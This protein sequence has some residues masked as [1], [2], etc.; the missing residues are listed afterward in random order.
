MTEIDLDKIH[1]R[2]ESYRDEIL[3]SLGNMIKIPAISPKS[4]GEGEEKKAEFILELIAN[5]GF[6]E[7][8]R[9]DVPDESA[10]KKIRPNIIAKVRGSKDPSEGTIWIVTHMDVVPEGE[11]ELWETPPYEPFVKDGKIFGRGVEDNGQGLISSLYAVKALK[12]EGVIPNRTIGIAL[13][14][15]EETGSQFGI[16]PLIEKGLF[17]ENDL[18]VV[19]DAGTSDGSMME[20][21]EKSI[22]WV[23]IKTIGK[24][25]H[26]SL[27]YKG[28]NA[29][30]A[31]MK[32]GVKLD[33]ELHKK[34]DKKDELFDPPESTFEPTKKESNV[35]N[36]NTIPGED[37][38]YFDCRVLPDYDPDEV[39]SMIKSIAKEIEEETRAKFQI[40]TPQYEPAAPP[41]SP[42]SPVVLELKEAIKKVYKIEPYAGGIGGGTCAALFRKAGY[43][44]VVWAKIDETAH[45]PN[46][47]AWIDNIV[48]DTKVYATLFC[49]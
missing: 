2:I 9:I 25:C 47:Y 23:K 24:Q 36:V 41:T 43:P 30:R 44:A 5:F 4:G 34:Y 8:D 1:Q 17:S 28:I 37:V 39:L 48:N 10:P 18:I 16:T 29:H 19:P 6:D 20:V 11:L 27:P 45:S 40:E 33:E 14:A 38:L 35:P 32:F 7:I 26:A 49:C 22:V 46:E 31:A 3:E 13:V 21:S 12:D 15:D 42:T